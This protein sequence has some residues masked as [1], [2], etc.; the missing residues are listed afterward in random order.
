[1]TAHL[2]TDQTVQ[3]SGSI[4]LTPETLK[5]AYEQLQK[6]NE[7]LQQQLDEQNGLISEKTEIIDKK[8]V[9]IGAQKKRI[10]ILEEH[11]RLANHKQYG[12]S[13]EKNALQGELFNEAELLAD[14]ESDV[15]GEITPELDKEEESPKKR[16]KRKGLSPDLV[17]EQVIHPLSDEEKQGAIDTFFVTVKEELDIIPAKARVL[18][19][20]QEKAVFLDADGKRSIKAAPRPAHPLGKA[21]A[22]CALLA[23]LIISKYADGLPLYRLEGILKRYGGQITRTTMANWLI[24]LSLQVQPVVNLLEE[25]MLSGTYMQGDETRMRVLKE[26]GTQA[27]STKY[28][29][30][31]RG[32]PPDRTVVMFNYDKSRGKAVAER[33]L[34]GFEGQYF[35]SDGYSGYDGACKAKGIS[36]LGCWDHARRKFL[37]SIKAAPKAKKTAKPSIAHIAVSKIDA[38]YRIERDIKEWDD[39]QKY[40]HRQIHSV[41]KL[42][43]LKLW[44][45]EKQPKVDPD[46][47][48]GKAI[49]YTLNQW[50]KLIR[51]CDHGS[52]NISNVL[53]ENAIRPFVVGRKAW[54]FADTPDGARASA[55]YYTLIE[56]AKANKIDP[57][58]YINFL[59]S[60]VAAVDTVEGYEALLPWNMKSTTDQDIQINTP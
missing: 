48:T 18:E 52:L 10:A 47:K 31:M 8:S 51:Y 25:T 37:E 19:H 21:I 57:Y 50:D 54:L 58:E 24:R 20:L 49:S 41:A 44:L 39:E 27:T 13:S 46:S 56:T 12:P 7:Q 26:P 59:I 9:V 35:Q 38:L 1:M 4:P 43:E 17:R 22:S 32:G 2:T 36:H 40:N 42:A 33:L 6:Q 29:W 55:I 5:V 15:S 28:M 30:V 3:D 14:G 16:K 11:I 23:Y 45:K 60:R 34:D 53:A